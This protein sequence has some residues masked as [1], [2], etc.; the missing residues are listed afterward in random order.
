MK[1]DAPEAGMFDKSVESFP[2]KKKYIYLS[3]C[4]ISPLFSSGLRKQI[5]LATMQTEAGADLY[6]HYDSTLNALHAAAAELMR[7]SAD[8][9]AFVKNTTEGLSLIANSY[10]LEAGDQIVSYVHEYPANHYP[11]RVLERQ[12]GAELILL[13][14]R[15][16]TGA[17]PEG[18]PSGWSL[19]DLEQRLTKK[20]RLVALSHV[21]YH[22]G[23][24]ADLRAVGE[25]CHSRGIDLIVDAAQSLGALPFYPEECHVAAAAAS[26]WK[27]LMGPYGTGLLYTSASFRAKLQPIFVGAESM[28]QGLDYLDH[29]WNPHTTARQFEYSTSA[30]SLAAALEV[31][32]RE[33]P[34]RYGIE[35]IQAE[36]FRLQSLFLERIERSRFTP[37]LFPEPHRSGILSLVC[38]QIHPAVLCKALRKQG[39]MVTER[40]GYVRFAPH[41]HATDE[42]V[43]RAAE[44]MN[45]VS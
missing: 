13:P 39:V 20:T 25:L 24:A 34:L 44:V 26:G 41:I 35:A 27:W 10:P 14:D 6:R 22:S 18:S 36:L 32:L 30:L 23:H 37:L 28:R 29:T 1:P 40:G 12:R 42:E 38:N 31:C 15:D 7:T 4:G 33:V 16:L 3:H 11:W 43:Q 17:A 2:I 19:D 21:Q 45:G 5:E 9:I 8:N